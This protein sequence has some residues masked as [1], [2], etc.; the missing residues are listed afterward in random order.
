[1]KKRA[2]SAPNF[3]YHC[4]MVSYA[5]HNP[6]RIKCLF[7][8]TPTP[9]PLVQLG[10]DIPVLKHRKATKHYRENDKCES[11]AAF[12]L[13]EQLQNKSF[14]EVLLGRGTFHHWGFFGISNTAGC[15]HKLARRVLDLDEACI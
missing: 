12:A 3:R 4:R 14:S 13:S 5:E 7:S 10:M 11:Y 15:S 1:M 6:S 8:I 2:Y 9:R